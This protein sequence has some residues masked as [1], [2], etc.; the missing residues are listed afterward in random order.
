MLRED[1]HNILVSELISVT[2][3]VDTI[4]PTKTRQAIHIAMKKPDWVGLDWVQIG[5]MRFII[6][7]EKIIRFK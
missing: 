2:D 7:N 5:S 1:T 4:C 6:K 3:F